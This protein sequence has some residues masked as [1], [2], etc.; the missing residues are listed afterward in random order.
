VY[1]ITNSIEQSSSWVANRSSA[2]QEISRI[3]W[4]GSLEHSKQPD[5][6]PY[7]KTDRSSPSNFLKIH[8]DIILLSTS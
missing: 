5:A 2:S 3:L 7:P 6:C 1:I 4:K 8:F